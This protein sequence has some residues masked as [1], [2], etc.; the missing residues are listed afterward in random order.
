LKVPR[1]LVQVWDRAL[2]AAGLGASTSQLE[3][4]GNT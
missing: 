2:E 3:V 4:G 1:Y